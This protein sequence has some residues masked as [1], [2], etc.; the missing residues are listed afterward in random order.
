MKKKLLYIT[1]T[2][3]SLTLTFVYRE[4]FGLEERGF[5]INTVSMNRPARESVSGEA[6]DLLDSTLYLDDVSPAAKL[7]SLVSVVI[8]RPLKF[9]ECLGLFAS[10]SP[11]NGVR[12][13]LRLGYHLIEACYLSRQDAIRDIDH[14]HSHFIN[15]PT[16]LAMFLSVLVDR[17]FSFTMHASLI[18]LDPLAFR[19]KL[20][21]CSFCVSI[22]EYNKSYVV[23]EYGQH[24][25]NKIKIV[26]CGIHP[27]RMQ[28]MVPD[29]PPKDGGVVSLLGV[30]Q[31]TERKGFHFLVRAC[32]ELK[33][34]G[35]PFKCSIVGEGHQRPVLESLIS[36]LRVTDCVHLIGA[37]PQ[38]DMPGFLAAANVFVLPCVVASDGWRDGIPVALMEAMYWKIP[39]VS[40]NILGLPELIDNNI[41]GV[42]VEP[43]DVSGLADAIERLSGSREMRIRMGEQA[44]VKVLAE[45]NTEH[46]V[47]QLDSLF[48][49]Q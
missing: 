10:A 5:Q 17:P 4:I 42:L 21:R 18:W 48:H 32:A 26:H 39:V 24:L 22:S 13:Y 49:A 37:R 9:L 41:N 28:P 43:E 6:S 38:E 19:A 45:F 44:K 46:S 20:D 25:K 30:G 33:S 11:M 29:L 47:E 8:S 15:G 40:T 27:G 14:I 12:D 23:A 16:S 36:E 7:L 35:V 31:L 3:P 34:R 2:L 1:T